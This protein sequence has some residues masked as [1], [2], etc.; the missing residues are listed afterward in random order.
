MKQDSKQRGFSVFVI[1]LLILVLAALGLTGWY[2]WDKSR[3][4]DTA[5][6]SENKSSQ[7]QQ[8]NDA[9]TDERSVQPDQSEGGKYLVI[10]EWNVR[11]ALPEEL[12]GDIEYGI[13]TFSS[14]DQA[15][16]FAS[17]KLVSRA[18]DGICGLAPTND[19]AGQG[20]FGGTIALSRSISQPEEIDRRSFSKDGFWYTIE[21][22]N[23]GPC[24]EGDTGQ[25]KGRFN[26][27]VE[28]AV[29][30]LETAR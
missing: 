24:Y 21:A 17:K 3:A 8:K 28:T 16:Y 14:G 13:F 2:V 29:K 10:K 25:E 1:I 11:F 22:S 30:E 27:L 15:A 12:Q 23:G 19:S 18:P 26:V 5:K 7:V 6:S 20:I 9:K 4:D